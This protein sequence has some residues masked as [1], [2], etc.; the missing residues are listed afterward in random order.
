MRAQLLLLALV[1]A[2]CGVA[3][4]AEGALRTFYVDPAGNDGAAGSL[5]APWRT[6]QHAANVVQAG[7]QGLLVQ[8]PKD[9]E[10]AER[11][12]S[13]E[14]GSGHNEQVVKGKS[15]PGPARAGAF[16]DFSACLRANPG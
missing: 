11:V 13:A 14:L 2:S 6:L 12:Q 5:A 15:Y 3:S 16:E 7:D 8:S 10:R 9:L 4:H 1:L